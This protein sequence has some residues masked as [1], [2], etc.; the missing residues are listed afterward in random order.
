MHEITRTK[1][2]VLSM[3][4]VVSCKKKEMSTV[5]SRSCAFANAISGKFQKASCH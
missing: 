2:D 3:I 1:T 5:K 4:F